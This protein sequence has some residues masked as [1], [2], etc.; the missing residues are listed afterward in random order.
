MSDQPDT[1]APARLNWPRLNDQQR[2]QLAADLDRAAAELTA[3]H[4]WNRWD[5][6][7]VLHLAI[8]QGLEHIRY[9]GIAMVSPHTGR[10]KTDA[11]PPV[12][13]TQVGTIVLPPPREDLVGQSFA[14]DVE[15]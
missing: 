8:T 12:L 7:T 4:P 10:T 9:H 13:P 6:R 1:A 5:R 15:D 11:P 2:E 3:A 14:F